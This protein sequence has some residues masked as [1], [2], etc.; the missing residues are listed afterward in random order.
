MK[1]KYIIIGLVTLAIFRTFTVNGQAINS[2]EFSQ[3]DSVQKI[4]VRDSLKISD[5]MVTK[6][7]ALRDNYFK[8]VGQV[9]LNNQL[10]DQQQNDEVQ[11]I[12]KQNILNIKDLLGTTIYVKYVQLIKN[13]MK[14][15]NVMG[16]VLTDDGNN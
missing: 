16:N 11:I 9:R 6:L 8:K 5:S 3:I 13:R 2:K 7:Y 4:M 1:R 15:N 14:K 10:S 12:R